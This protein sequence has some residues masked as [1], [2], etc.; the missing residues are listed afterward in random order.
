MAGHEEHTRR[1]GELRLH[2]ATRVC[3]ALSMWISRATS[4]APHGLVIVPF[5]DLG[6]HSPLNIIRL[7]EYAGMH[8]A[9]SAE[10]HLC[11]RAKQAVC[12]DVL[13]LLDSRPKLLQ[14]R[15]L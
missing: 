1:G 5:A 10:V 6:N 12:R 13:H 4:V 11:G 15:G 9:P 8:S 3:W 7:A 2:R 14:W